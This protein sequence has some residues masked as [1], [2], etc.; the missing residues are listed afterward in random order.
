MEI[1]DYS[2]GLAFE[3]LASF[4]VINAVVSFVSYSPLF[5]CDAIVAPTVS[6]LPSR[7]IVRP[8]S[9][10]EIDLSVLQLT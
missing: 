10:P 9:S 8:A 6:L 1:F 7:E 3:T 2:H 4:L 5:S